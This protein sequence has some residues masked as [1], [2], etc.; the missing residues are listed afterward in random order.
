MSGPSFLNLLHRAV[1]ARGLL[2]LALV[3]VLAGAACAIFNR[4]L[5]QEPGTNPR[6]GPRTYL[7]E[8]N[9][10]ALS[11]DV[12]A[13]LRRES[14]PYIPVAVAIANKSVRRLTLGRESFTLVDA[15]GN[16]YPLAAVK[17][18]RDAKVASDYEVSRLFFEIVSTSYRGYVYVPCSFFPPSL[19]DPLRRR[20]IVQDH[21]ELETRMWTADM[22]Y[23][24]HPKGAVA[25]RQFELWMTAPELPDPVF[26]KFRVK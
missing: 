5:P 18:A 15:E 25:G 7:E 10:V 20:P 24:P 22:L 14:S 3:P 13:A 26:V 8:G 16:R 9:L 1:A 12:S 21:V 6:L 17:G 23:F 2:F 19:R 11:A 4:P